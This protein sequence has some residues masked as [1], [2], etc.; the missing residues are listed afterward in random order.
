MDERS[1]TTRPEDSVLVAIAEQVMM[2]RKLL[3]KGKWL[4]DELGI[5]LRELDG[6]MQS[7]GLIYAE[8]P[9]DKP[10]I[11]LRPA[12]TQRGNAGKSVEAYSLKMMARSLRNP[13]N[14]M[15]SL[16]LD[17]SRLQ[18]R[19]ALIDSLFRLYE[20][21]TDERE[22]ALAKQAASPAPA[23]ASSD[24]VP[25][26]AGDGSHL[27]S[28]RKPIVSIDAERRKQLRR[29]VMQL[30]KVRHLFEHNPAA[31]D[32]ILDRVFAEVEAGELPAA[33]VDGK[34]LNLVYAES[35]GTPGAEAATHS[36]P[37]ALDSDSAREPSK[38]G[39]AAQPA[40]QPRVEPGQADSANTAAI[41][42][43]LGNWAAQGLAAN[44]LFRRIKDQGDLERR[45]AQWKSNGRAGGEQ[46]E[47]AFVNYFLQQV[48][49]FTIDGQ[50]F[51]FELP[52]SI[53]P[54]AC[55]DFEALVA[56]GKEAG[57][58]GIDRRIWGVVGTAFVFLKNAFGPLLG[59]DSARHANPGKGGQ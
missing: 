57:A 38:P 51:S 3:Q 46:I 9:G 7:A 20:L 59:I 58:Y 43:R 26:G 37:T 50:T 23:P 39:I 18:A 53:G 4:C 12:P 35:G 2:R 52:E 44:Q 40:G 22:L 6:L 49:R 14:M 54:L 45:I 8:C 29:Q 30:G 10:T 15:L 24:A 56:Q 32:R 47:R 55:S 31:F 13:G 16:T 5:A 28:S 34:I 36:P 19:K 25:A 33:A 42:E 27:G 21:V 48:S 41:P 11:I 17:A 1:A